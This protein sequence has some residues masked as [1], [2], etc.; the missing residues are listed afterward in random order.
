MELFFCPAFLFCFLSILCGRS[1]YFRCS[2]ETNWL[3]ICTPR[4]DWKM[5]LSPTTDSS[6]SR[7]NVDAMDDFALFYIN[8][9]AKEKAHNP[10]GKT[11]TLFL[12]DPSGKR[13]LGLANIHQVQ[14]MRALHELAGPTGPAGSQD[15]DR[16]LFC[17]QGGILDSP[18]EEETGSFF[19]SSFMKTRTSA[20]VDT[21]WR[22]RSSNRH[23]IRPFATTA[24][25]AV[26]G[27]PF[28]QGFPENL[29]RIV[30]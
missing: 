10:A 19:H 20:A 26:P 3:V 18:R 4:A 8:Q 1:F 6:D 7:L 24:V 21:R 27:V 28:C 17:S 13:R 14:E 30:V 25:T 23:Y 5:A 16:I 2:S 9:L 12:T 11:P 15:Q 22:L 29:E